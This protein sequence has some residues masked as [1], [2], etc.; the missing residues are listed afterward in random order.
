[1]DVAVIG[2]GEIG[3]AV[4]RRLL[5][6]GHDVIACD[7]LQPLLAEASKA[8]ARVTS[9]ASHCA[10][11]DI[12][13]IAVADDNQVRD[14]MQGTDGL[15]TNDDR[16]ST[17]L[18]VVMSTVSVQAVHDLHAVAH[19]RGVPLID[20]PLSGGAIRAL[21]GTLTL[22]AGGEQ[23]D[24]QRARSVLDDIAATIFHCGP[25]GSGA[26]LKIINNLICTSSVYL[27]AEAFR[28][29]EE[30]GV[31]LNDLLPVLDTSSGRTFLSGDLEYTLGTYAGITKTEE[32]FSHTLASMRKDLSLAQGLAQ[33]TPGRYP[34]LAGLEATLSSLG[35]ETYENW[36]KVGQSNTASGAGTVVE[37]RS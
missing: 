2:L 3:F 13:L 31:R 17:P 23:S 14:V 26:L 10:D 28:L 21:E 19:E 34:M 4:M 11:A 1:M 25:V 6:C 12:V 33:Q 9:R 5:E 7:R 35:S 32:L 8:G 29:A 20:A 37:G 27:S 18:V 36:A 22:M 15:L 30:N 16:T 24:I